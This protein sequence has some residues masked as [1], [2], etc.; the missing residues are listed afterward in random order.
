MCVN[1]LFFLVFRFDYII[2]I[3]VTGFT[4]EDRKE[5]MEKRVISYE[6]VREI[7]RKKHILHDFMM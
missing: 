6:V 3:G 5:M 1:P 2:Y 7:R 4:I